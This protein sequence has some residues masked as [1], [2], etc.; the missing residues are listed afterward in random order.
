MLANANGRLGEYELEERPFMETIKTAKYSDR[1]WSS[2]TQSTVLLLFFIAY[3]CSLTTEHIIGC[4]HT[5]YLGQ[6]MDLGGRLV[7]WWRTRGR[8]EGCLLWWT[9]HKQNC[10]VGVFVVRVHITTRRKS[11]KP[12]RYA[13]DGAKRQTAGYN[14]L[15]PQK[16][17]WS[18]SW[19]LG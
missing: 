7:G 11:R 17:M 4:C 19:T 1:K 8:E 15:P 2:I 10:L 6:V 5:V 16:A 12:S 18:W 3:F 9:L 13:Y 14:L